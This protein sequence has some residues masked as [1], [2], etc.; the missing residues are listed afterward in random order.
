MAFLDFVFG[1]HGDEI[2]PPDSA[3]P[4]ATGSCRFYP[5]DC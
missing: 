2:I 4:A 1:Y 5:A 3:I